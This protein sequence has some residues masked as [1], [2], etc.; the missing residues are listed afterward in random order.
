MR[1][2]YHFFTLPIYRQHVTDA[3][4]HSPLLPLTTLAFPIRSAPLLPLLPLY[5]QHVIDATRHLPLAT[6]HSCHSC[7][8][9]KER[10]TAATPSTL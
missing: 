8:A 9:Y 3:N 5:R 7:V 4:C 1:L 2:S 6:R 10:A